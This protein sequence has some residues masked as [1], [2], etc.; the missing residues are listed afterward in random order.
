[1]SRSQSLDDIIK[2]AEINKGKDLFRVSIRKKVNPKHIS[3]DQGAEGNVSYFLLDWLN[4]HQVW[5][6]AKLKLRKQIIAS[7]A[8][9]PNKGGDTAKYVSTAFIKMEKSDIMGGDYVME[10]FSS[11]TSEI[12]KKQ[13]NEKFNKQIETIYNN[14]QKLL[15]VLE[16][17]SNAYLAFFEKE[18]KNP[19]YRKQSYI[20]QKELHTPVQKIADIDGEDKVLENPI[21]R[22]QLPVCRYTKKRPEMKPFKD[23]IGRWNWSESTLDPIV[24][25]PDKKE[26]KFI[27]KWVDKKGKKKKKEIKLNLKNVGKIITYKSLTSGEINFGDVTCSSQGCNNKWSWWKMF[28]VTYKTKSSDTMTVEDMEDLADLG[29]FKK[30][31]SDDDEDD[32]PDIETIEKEQKINSDSDSDIDSSTDDSDSDS[33]ESDSNSKR[34]KIIKK[35]KNKKQMKRNIDSEPDEQSDS[36]N[37]SEEPKMKI[38]IKK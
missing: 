10:E 1:M 23:H 29:G 19:A 17:I 13:I 3:E 20:K 21:Y 22:I 27:E 9:P 32:M 31:V 35:K 7:K 6:Q 30:Q 14:N 11:E 36:D 25:N 4:Q 34:K 2:S 28:I 18:R 15:K 5:V 33:S 16:I 8:K 37:D 38:R 26:A 24:F 12:K